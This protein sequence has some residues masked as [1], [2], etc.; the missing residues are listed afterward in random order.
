MAIVPPTVVTTSNNVLMSGRLE[1]CFNHTIGSLCDDENWGEEE[2]SVA[3]RQLGFSP[4]GNTVMSLNIIIII[5]VGARVL[6]GEHA[7]GDI[8]LSN[9]QCNGSENILL[10]CQFDIRGSNEYMI[11]EDHAGVTCQG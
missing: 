7:V 5:C 1:M 9:I 4:Y 6:F 8:L 2:V 3:C 11:C 10:D